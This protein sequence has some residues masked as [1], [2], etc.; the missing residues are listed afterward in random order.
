MNRI[1]RNLM[2]VASVA[3]IWFAID[4]AGQPA[5]ARRACWPCVT[6]C[7]Q[8]LIMACNEACGGIPDGCI[9]DES[10]FIGSARVR[11]EDA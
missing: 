3:T 1:T 2:A 5:S 6:T 11:C 7:S 8:G 4:G 9:E 10:C